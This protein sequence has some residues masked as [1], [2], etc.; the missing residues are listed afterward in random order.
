M[1]LKKATAYRFPYD[2]KILFPVLLLLGIG[3]A[4]LYSASSAISRQTHGTDYFYLQRQAIFAVLGICALMV[5]RYFPY[6]WYRS[7]S[8]PLLGAAIVMLVAVLIMGVKAGGATRWLSLGGLTFQPS[9]FARLAVIIFF[10]YS[11]TKKQD[12]LSSF[13][14]GFL[15]HVGVLFVFAALILMEPDFGSMVILFA[16]GWVMMFA[17]GVRLLHLLLPLIPIIPAGIYIMLTEPYRLERLLAFRDP[18]KYAADQGY[19]IVHSQMAFGTGGIFGNGIGNGYQ[20]L[21]FLPEPHTDFIFS[22]IGEELGLLG[23]LAI[24]TLYAILVFRGFIIAR[25]SKDM[26]ATI[27]AVG[28]TTA[29]GIQVIINIGVT[30]GLLPPKGLPL[31]FLSY[32]GT[33][34]LVS[35]TAAGILMNIDASHPVKRARNRSNGRRAK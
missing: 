16:I 32:G 4:M 25:N 18:W 13:K 29:I 33:S 28:M 22:V 5:G 24:L 27:L 35:M 17:G 10:A 19:Q 20:K 9:E 26:F 15:P 1:T 12:Q 11:L 14:I 31:P 3:L 8:Y 2:V 21:F 23:V 30:L 34:L 7:L 6:R